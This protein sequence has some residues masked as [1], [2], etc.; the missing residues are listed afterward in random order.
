MVTEIILTGIAIGLSMWCQYLWDLNKHKKV[1][2]KQLQSDLNFY[3]GQATS[4]AYR[5]YLAFLE[6]E[7]KNPQLYP[8]FRVGKKQRR[9]ILDHNGQELGIFKSGSEKEAQAYCD[10]LNATRKKLTASD[11]A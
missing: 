7:Y 2:I 3:K 5:R 1:H 11:P 8:P 9:V 10:Y 6:R 4:P